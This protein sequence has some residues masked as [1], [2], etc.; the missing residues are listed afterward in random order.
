MTKKLLYAHI[1]LDRSGSMESCR[2]STIDAVNE[3][4]GALAKDQ[5]TDAAV[6]LSLFDSDHSNNLALDLVVDG[7][8]AG[9]FPKL[10]RDTFVPRGSTPLNDAIGRTVARIDGEWHH[11]GEG[12]ALVIMT[13][14][15]ENASRE[16]KKDAIKALL[17]DRQ[18]AKNWLVIYLGANQDA[19]A[20]GA[21][22]GMAMANTMSFD[23]KNVRATMEAAARSTSTYSALGSAKLAA[24]TD[25][26]RK[27]ARA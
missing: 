5:D 11:P 22:R 8:K 9:E 16:F 12:I 4:V 19:F 21:A 14:G 27:K 7:K 23:T 24:F 17:E 6:S 1:L 2:D 18:K 3:Y 13:D 15:Q 26:E 10:T 20:E 25:E